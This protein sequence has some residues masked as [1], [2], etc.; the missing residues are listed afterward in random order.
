MA[1]VTEA[2]YRPRIIEFEGFVAVEAIEAVEAELR[3]HAKAD[4]NQ[5][6]GYFP[7]MGEREGIG[8]D[9]PAC[10]EFAK[11]YPTITPDG[12]HIPLGFNFLRM[13]RIRQPARSPYHI[14]SDAAT[15]LTGDVS[16][17]ADRRVWRF[18]MN[19]NS[20]HERTLSY[21]DIDPFSVELEAG[22]GYIHIGDTA[23]G[24][25]DIRTI[26]VPPRDGHTVSGVL[27][28]VNHVL[29][30][31]KDDEHGHFI[32]SYGAEEVA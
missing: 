21:L 14:D 2:A 20:K 27:L 28:S 4:S 30:T 11:R 22:D 6:Y 9:L 18:L 32:A 23:V 25:N 16:D 29:H 31:G 3:L 15:A 24:P 17:I 12:F 19:L 7:S 13:S 5:S 26:D 10:Q 8:T 1:G